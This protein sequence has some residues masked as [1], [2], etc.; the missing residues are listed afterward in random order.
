LQVAW[1]VDRDTEFA[2]RAPL[3]TVIFA[4]TVVHTADIDATQ[5]C[6]ELVM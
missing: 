3:R 2:A 6:K 1:V 4:T 5:G